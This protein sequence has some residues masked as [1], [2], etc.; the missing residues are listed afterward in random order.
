MHITDSHVSGTTIAKRRPVRPERRKESSGYG[1]SR[2]RCI[3]TR[4]ERTRPL[5]P[6]VGALCSRIARSRDECR[7]RSEHLRVPLLGV[8]YVGIERKRIGDDDIPAAAGQLRHKSDENALPVITVEERR[9]VA[10][11]R[12]AQS[13]ATTGSISIAVSAELC[14]PI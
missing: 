14:E 1:E 3:P 2:V 6:I 8:P 9:L 5:G 7:L 4:V 10:P 13:S 11:R 12:C